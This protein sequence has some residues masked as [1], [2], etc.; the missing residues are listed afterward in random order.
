M[1]RLVVT[2]EADADASE[3]ITYLH[4]EAGIRVAETYKARFERLLSRLV[5]V[6]RIGAPRP[7]LGPYTRIAIVQPYLLIYDL[8]ADGETITLLR[9]LHSRRNI[10][11]ELFRR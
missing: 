9:I 3:I 7:A 10:T 11:P 5:Q 2:P 1:T 6:P 8:A 4:R